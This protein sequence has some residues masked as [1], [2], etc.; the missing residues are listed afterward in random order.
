MGICCPNAHGKMKR[1]GAKRCGGAMQRWRE[2][3]G[4]FTA[5]EK[6]LYT[7]NTSHLAVGDQGDQREH[8]YGILGLTGPYTWVVG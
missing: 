6:R 1:E 4:Q 8:W 5:V 3:W 7:H 2:D